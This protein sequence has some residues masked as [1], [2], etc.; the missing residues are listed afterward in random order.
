[1]RPCPVFV[2]L[3]YSKTSNGIFDTKNMFL[4]FTYSLYTLSMVKCSPSGAASNAFAASASLRWLL[5]LNHTFGTT[6]TW[7]SGKKVT[8][9]LERTRQHGS[10]GQDFVAAFELWAHDE[11]FG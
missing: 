7:I 6:L 3:V 1:V 5:G 4:L 2:V 9:A 10:N 8:S 11:H